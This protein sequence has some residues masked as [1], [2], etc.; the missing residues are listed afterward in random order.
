MLMIVFLS[1]WFRKGQQEGL[2]KYLPT[3]ETVGFSANRCAPQPREDILAMK[4]PT[5]DIRAYTGGL[6]TCHHKWILLDDEQ[7]YVTR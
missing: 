6:L 4:N 7:E 2:I 5:C 3:G 1:V